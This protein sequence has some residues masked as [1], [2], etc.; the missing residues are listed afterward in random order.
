MLKK[1]ERCLTN[2]TSPTNTRKLYPTMMKPQ[3]QEF[4]VVRGLGGIVLWPTSDL[5][6]LKNNEK[7]IE[8]DDEFR[9]VTERIFPENPNDSPE[10]P[11]NL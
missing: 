11:L 5:L 3:P 10:N 6:N 2:A 8:I 1:K 7:H 9:P 4:K